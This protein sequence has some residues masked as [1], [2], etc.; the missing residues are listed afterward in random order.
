MIKKTDVYLKRGLEYEINSDRKI[1]K[2]NE[3]VN[4]IHNKFPYGTVSHSFNAK[5]YNLTKTSMRCPICDPN[6]TDKVKE[7][8][9]ILL[10]EKGISYSENYKRKGLTKSFDFV[11]FLKNRKV[12]INYFASNFYVNVLNERHIIQKIDDY[13]KE[14]HIVYLKLTHLNIDSEFIKINKLIKKYNE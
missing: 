8:I 12:Y 14:K 10:N 9:R 5:A 13:C 2:N 7:K 3:T 1:F 6:S 11:L 4:I